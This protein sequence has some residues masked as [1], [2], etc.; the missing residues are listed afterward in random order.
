MTAPDTEELGGQT[1]HSGRTLSTGAVQSIQR[2]GE[3]R[4][5]RL[6]HR[7]AAVHPVRGREPRSWLTRTVLGTVLSAQARGSQKKLL[8]NL[9]GTFYISLFVQATKSGLCV[10][11]QGPW[12]YRTMKQRTELRL[13]HP[14]IP[15]L[16]KKKNQNML[17]FAVYF[18]LKTDH[19]FDEAGK[20]TLVPK[21]YHYVIFLCKVLRTSQ[22]PH[23][24]TNF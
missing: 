10:Q 13:G 23:S 11:K 14:Q 6:S 19:T 20:L 9:E 15:P 16:L 22:K 4:R 18:C 2:G 1:N 8:T 7:L 3:E 5:G 17:S 21:S 12:G 24:M